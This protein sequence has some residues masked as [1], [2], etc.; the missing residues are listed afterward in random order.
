MATL[1]ARSF[2]PHTAGGILTLGLLAPGFA[3]A[4]P[5]LLRPATA[6]S[7]ATALSAAVPGVMRARPA[8]V[9][10]TALPDA[11]A[12]ANVA[13]AIDARVR[14]DLFDDRSVVAA[15]DR[16]E[17]SGASLI[18]AGH[19]EDDP[20]SRFLAVRS[21]DALV[22]DVVST[23]ARVEIRFTGNATHL[24]QQIDPSVVPACGTV[25]SARPGD[26]AAP[27]PV[28]EAGVPVE[29]AVVEPVTVDALIVFTTQAQA[30]A[31]GPAGAQ[32]LAELAIQ[33][34]ND[35]LARS[36]VVHRFRLAGVATTAY[37]ESGNYS[38]DNGRI[39]NAS[40]G[41]MDEIPALRNSLNADVVALAVE[42]PDPSAGGVGYVL[43]RFTKSESGW[44]YSTNRR[45]WLTSRVLAHELGHNLGLAHDRD[46]WTGGAILPYVYGYQLL[47]VFYTIMAYPCSGC[48]EIVYYSNPDVPYNGIPTGVR[49]FAEEARALQ[50]TAPVIASYRGCPSD[51][52]QVD[53][54]IPGEGG[55]VRFVIAIGAGCWWSIEPP[56]PAVP[57]LTVP[58]QTSGTGPVD[59]VFTA[60]ALPAGMS[61]RTASVSIDGRS[62]LIVQRA[63]ID[64]DTDALPDWWELRYGLSSAS[65]T[66]DNGATGDPDNDG[67]TNLEEYQAG[68]HPRG[69]VKRYLAE[70][71]AGTFFKTRYALLNPGLVPATVLLR[72]AKDGG[73]STTHYLA[74]PARGR[75]TVTSDQVVGLGIASFSTLIESDVDIVVDRTMSWDAR[76]YGSHAETAIV[77][78]ATQWYLAE[79]STP[80]R[81]R[82]SICCRTRAR[83]RSP[84]RCGSSCRSARRSIDHAFVAAAV[85]HHDPGGRTAP[86]AHHHRRVRVSSPRPRRSSWSARC[87]E[88]RRHRRLPPAT[89]SAGVTAPATTWFLAEGATGSFFDLFILLANPG[90]SD[91]DV[92]VQYLLRS[93]TTYSKTTPF[94]PT[95]GSPS[96]WTTRRF[97]ASR[98]GRW[99]TSPCRAPS[100]RPTACPSSSNARCGGRVPG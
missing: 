54:E 73:G 86:R 26:P 9:D 80:T 20:A 98:A 58:T 16:I 71:A 19:L 23:S 87:I 45:I 47:G 41:F 52:T 18:Y 88:A 67:R 61:S 63:S 36:L 29:A 93:G 3:S 77:A 57:W 33:T 74:V 68:T 75:R 53:P 8:I 66:G 24:V 37:A 42:G 48:S 76:G 6:D 38:L 32:A 13:A 78:P 59:V 7:G 90:A 64:A 12:G 84:R 97:P 82:S 14:L 60:A 34:V 39:A 55:P 83:R 62:F 31:G 2:C 40:D 100:R 27:A 49:D 10:F 43:S 56:N 70:G 44:A 25:G 95:A 22:A 51:V 81:S 65:A 15:L 99:P 46:N 4:Q 89:R 21:G 1:R 92:R 85:A 30:G 72:L 5:R 69:F 11:P 94:A 28:A 96:G 79:G 35:A 50:Q 91:A 17:R